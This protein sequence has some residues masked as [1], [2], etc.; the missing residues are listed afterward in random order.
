MILR[1]KK[2][3]I[4]A[5]PTSVAIDQVRV[6]S[7]LATGETGILLAEALAKK[8]AKVTLLL[9]VNSCCLNKKIKVVPFRFFD[10]LENKLKH[11]LKNSKYDIVVH[12]AAVSDYRP[13]QYYREKVASGIKKWHLTLIPTPKLITLIKKISPWSLLI[14][15]KYDYGANKNILIHNAKRLMCNTTADMVVANTVQKGNYAAYIIK[16]EKIEGI[17]RSKNILVRRLLVEL[18]RITDYELL[19]TKI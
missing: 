2:V 15:F 1:N 6:I 11:E 9:G 19:I 7:N 14:G 4:T 10:E 17:F 8:G 16:P 5:G 12:S 18:L 13:L 3:L